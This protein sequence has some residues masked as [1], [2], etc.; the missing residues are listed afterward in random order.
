[1]YIRIAV[2]PE[3]TLNKSTYVCYVVG[4]SVLRQQKCRDSGHSR[5][6]KGSGLIFEEME[7]RQRAGKE[8]KTPQGGR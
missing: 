8:W 7:E 2:P 5:V 4:P 6:I 1:M 3:S